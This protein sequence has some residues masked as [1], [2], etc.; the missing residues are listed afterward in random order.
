MPTSNSDDRRRLIVAAALIGVAFVITDH[1]R[2][3]VSF[4]ASS[5]DGSV[6]SP[7]LATVVARLGLLA[8]MAAMAF[9]HGE[10]RRVRWS[11]TFL[12]VVVLVGYLALSALWSPDFSFT[13]RKVIVLG[14]VVATAAC[15]AATF[16]LRRLIDLVLIVFVAYLMLGAVYEVATGS[17]KFLRVYRFAGT[18]GANQNGVFAAVIALI[19]AGRLALDK[20]VRAAPQWVLIAFAAFFTMITMSRTAMVAFVAAL[21]AA[22][23]AVGLSPHS[24]RRL[25]AAM[26]AVITLLVAGVVLVLSNDGRRYNLTQIGRRDLIWEPLLTAIGERP[27]T[28]YGY[29]GYWVDEGRNSVEDAHSIYVEL[30]LDGGVIALVLF[31]VTIG[32]AMLRQF[33]ITRQQLSADHVVALALLAF[34]LVQGLAES[35]FIRP[36]ISLFFLLCL[37]LRTAIES[38]SDFLPVRGQRR[39]T[40]PS[41]G[42]SR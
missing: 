29:L 22:G 10:W 1:N 24:T 21:V 9:T 40:T 11:P 35:Q 7:V 19:C 5:G 4:A 25:R 41:L 31:L 39:S 33:V 3:F 18:T 30:L 34:A 13:V 36:T 14:I 8:A 38:G 17:V 12:P 20:G 15:T 32:A 42:V 37:V 26:A 16:D 28:G 6:A 2:E 23:I 27:I